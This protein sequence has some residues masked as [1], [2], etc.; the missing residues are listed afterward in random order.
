VNNDYQAWHRCFR[1]RLFWTE[2]S[3]RAYAQHLW[4]EHG[5]VLDVYPCELGNQ[6]AHFHVGHRPPAARR[7]KLGRLRTFGRQTVLTGK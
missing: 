5:S 4:A 3:A 7:E 2:D 6:E 1:K